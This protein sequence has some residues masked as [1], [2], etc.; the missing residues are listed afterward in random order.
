MK[1]EGDVEMTFE[2]GYAELNGGILA[3]LLD[4]KDNLKPEEIKSKKKD[5]DDYMRF[6][7]ERQKFALDSEIRL[8]EIALKE[9]ESEI[10]EKQK[11]RELD[12]KKRELD[13]SER[14]LDIEEKRVK[15]EFWKTIADIAGD[16]IGVGELVYTFGQTKDYLVS[17]YLL[18]EE[19]FMP[20]NLGKEAKMLLDAETRNQ[21][22]R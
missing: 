10:H 3:E 18:Q 7:L 13:I 12:L 8:R 2:D 11:K 1:E 5:I 14:K 15:V 20:G 17:D 22:P 19:G 21:L 16:L 4:G 9:K 6:D